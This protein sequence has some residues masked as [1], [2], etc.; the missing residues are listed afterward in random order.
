MKTRLIVIKI[1]KKRKTYCPTAFRKN[2]NIKVTISDDI[3]LKNA[4]SAIAE[5]LAFCLKDS[6]TNIKGM[7]PIFFFVDKLI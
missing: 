6:A 7:G 4:V 3:Q 5:L 1:I 2:G